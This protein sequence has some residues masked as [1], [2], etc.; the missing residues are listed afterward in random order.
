MTGAQRAKLWRQPEA[1]A[2]AL[3]TRLASKRN[4]AR[5]FITLAFC[6]IFYNFYSS[7]ELRKSLNDRL[8]QTMSA[9]PSIQVVE[10]TEPNMPICS[11]EPTLESNNGTEKATLVMLVRNREIREALSSMRSVEDRFNRKFHYP[12]TF[13]N[14][15]PFTKD[16]IEYTTGMA[17]GP[18]EYQVIPKEAWS[19]PKSINTTIV[20]QEMAEMTRQNIIYG[21]SLSYRHM[22]RFNS[23]F[24]YNMEVMKKYDWYW[25]VEP[26]IELYCDIEYDPFTFMRT[27]N[28]IY[29]FVITMYEF[30]ATIKT[31]WSR[32]KES[33]AYT[34]YFEFL[35]SAG[36][37]F[38]E[39]WGDAPVHSLGVGLFAPKDK[40]HHFADFGYSHPPCS[41]CPQ[42]DESHKSGRCYCNRAVNFDTNSYSCMPRWWDVAGINKG[43][44][45]LNT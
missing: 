2:G 15:K 18:V 1:A 8:Q 17:S 9:S 12:W 38:Y 10:Q 31:L 13:L 7:S 19:I 14:D 20:K 26:G 44:K 3:Y 25:R 41:R 32:T 34:K 37:F 23:G 16:F 36:G 24:F 6:A 39:R 5:V 40:I 43:A 30:E 21:G 4:F 22:C 42:D 29:G 27:N 35:D 11:N 33:E 28:K 45:R